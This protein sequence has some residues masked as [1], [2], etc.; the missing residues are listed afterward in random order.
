MRVAWFQA[1]MRR[2]L[3]SLRSLQKQNTPRLAVVAV[4]GFTL[5]GA[6]LGWLFKPG[7]PDAETLAFQALMPGIAEEMVYRGIAP[8]IL[9]GLILWKRG[10]DRTPWAVI[11]ATSVLFGIWHSLDYSH[12]KLGFDLLSGLFPAIGSVV[13]G[14]LRFR[15]GSLLVPVLGHSFANI[16][17]H[18]VGEI[19]T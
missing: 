12:G 5:W 8:A 6:C 18:L 15:T 4:C 16:A 14:W 7:R 13:R 1:R 17:F 11:A 19:V 9:M 10:P 2:W 3:P